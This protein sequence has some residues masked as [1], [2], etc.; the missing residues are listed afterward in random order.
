MSWSLGVKWFG[1]FFYISGEMGE[2]WSFGVFY[3]SLFIGRHSSIC[4]RNALWP[5]GHSTASELTYTAPKS[6][7]LGLMRQLQS[8][9]RSLICCCAARQT[10]CCEV[11]AGLLDATGSSYMKE[12]ANG[13][14]VPGGPKVMPDHWF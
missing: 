13:P 7:E 4:L 9:F 6:Q 11:P 14:L 3:G 8:H 2:L 10:C 5:C 12:L 1:V